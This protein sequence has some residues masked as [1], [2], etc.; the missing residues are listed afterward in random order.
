[1]AIEPAGGGIHHTTDTQVVANDTGVFR[2][3]YTAQFDGKDYPIKGGALETVSLKK[4]DDLTF[5]RTGKVKG[6]VAETSTWK[7]SPDGKTLTVTTKGKID[8]AE[9]SNT[10]VLD[11]TN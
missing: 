8:R 7:L 2:T 11:R 10:Q 1:M 6:A 3:E 4:I 5:E 9:Y